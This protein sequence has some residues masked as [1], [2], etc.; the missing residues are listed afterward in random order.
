[1]SEFSLIKEIIELSSSTIWDGAKIEWELD[2]I[3]EAEDQDAARVGT[4]Q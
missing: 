3:Y 2:D 1:M 4:F